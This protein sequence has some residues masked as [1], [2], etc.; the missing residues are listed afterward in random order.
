MTSS[1][2]ESPPESSRR[3]TACRLAVLGSPI[4]HSKS[5]QLHLAAYQALGLDWEYT[6]A[7]VAPGELSDFVLGLDESWR[8]LSLTMPLKE[9]VL[10]LIDSADVQSLL[11]GA[12]NTVLFGRS[13]DALSVQGFNTDVGGIVDALAGTGISRSSEVLIL[14]AGATARSSVVAAAELGAEHVTIAA[15][16]PQKAEQITAVATNAGVAVSVVWLADVLGAEVDAPVTISTLPG[17]AL[18]AADIAGFAPTPGAALLDVAY[19]PWPSPLAEAWQSRGG[20][21][22][23]GL[24]MLAHQALAQVRIFVNGDPQLRLAD[25][26]AVFAAMTRAIG[27][28]A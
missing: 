17:G 4:A 23:S 7:D 26:P 13:G 22:V 20:V 10:S 16:S 1:A 28:T 18:T 6:R 25:E 11:T 9:E 19:D 8:G 2:P 5:P 3:P 27:L 12:A 14:G 15:R 21:A 24:W